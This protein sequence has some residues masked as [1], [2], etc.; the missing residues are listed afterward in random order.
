MAARNWDHSTM[1]GYFICAHNFDVKRAIGLKN[2][3]FQYQI[4]S[5]T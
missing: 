2:N 1:K 3:G 4:A 5:F